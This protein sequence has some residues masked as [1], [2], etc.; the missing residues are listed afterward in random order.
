MTTTKKLLVLLVLAVGACKADDSAGI[1]IRGRAAPNDACEFAASGDFLLGEG[2]LDVGPAYA[3]NPFALQYTLVAY[4][5]NNLADPAQA[6]SA[7]PTVGK[8]WFAER[9]KVH[10]EPMGLPSATRRYVVPSYEVPVAGSVAQDMTLVEPE[11]AG[12]LGAGLAAGQARQVI[13]TVTLEGVT[14]DGRRL[15]SN[16]WQYGLQVCNGCLAPPACAGGTLVLAACV[17]PGQDSPPFCAA[18][19]P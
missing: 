2:V 4:V 9:V 14:A 1:L 15:D 5:T 8:S 6:S 18:A 11:L 17:P 13:L 19:A 3:A 10:A 7:T 16:E 12:V